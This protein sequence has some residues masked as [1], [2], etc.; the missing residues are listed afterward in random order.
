GNEEEV[1]KYFKQF[2]VDWTKYDHTEGSRERQNEINSIRKKE[3]FEEQLKTLKNNL[4]NIKG[5]ETS[6]PTRYEKNKNRIPGLEKKISEYE[7]ILRDY[8]AYYKKEVE[9]INKKYEDSAK[10]YIEKAKEDA[11]PALEALDKIGPLFTYADMS[12]NGESKNVA[13]IASD[14]LTKVG[15]DDKINLDKHFDLYSMYTHADDGNGYGYG[16]VNGNKVSFRNEIIAVVTLPE[17]IDIPDKDLDKN[18]SSKNTNYKVT[19]V[20]KA[21]RKLTIKLKSL[22]E[23]KYFKDYKKDDIPKLK[24]TDLNIKGL[25]FNDKTRLGEKYTI[26][27][28]VGG[29][30]LFAYGQEA[31]AYSAFAARQSSDGVDIASSSSNVISLTLKLKSNTV[32]FKVD[33]QPDK[34]VL[35]ETGKSINGDV[36]NTQSMPSD[37]TKSGYTFKGW[38]TQPNGGGTRF[39]GNTPVNSDITVY[40][41]FER[42]P[43]N[44]GGG[45]GGGTTPDPGRVDG[46]DRVETGIKI[47]QKY[48]DKAKTVIVVRHDLFP[49]SMTA[50]VLAKLK[51]APILLNPTNKLDPRVGAEIKRLGAEEVIIVGGPDSISEKVRGDLKA[52]DKDKDVERIAGVDRYGT[53]EMVARRVTGITGK[54]NTGV[55]ASGQVFP[56]ALSVGTFA[57]RDGYPI[58]LVKKNLVPDQVVRA[59][60]DLDIKKT[61]I[62]GGTNTISKSTEA[63]LPGVLERMAGKDR[64]E[65]SVAI[66]KSKFK[67]SR[68]AFIASGEEFADALVIS[69]VSGKYNR[70]T[71]LAS[72]N[73]K[74]NAVVKKYI[75][76][77]YLTSITAIGGEKYLPKSIMLD[78]AG[79]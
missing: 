5:W 74:T 7:E 30:G 17:N 11:K 64:Y 78:L 62:A 68:E 23:N 21:G 3:S 19:S 56:D 12:I 10:E 72:R 59:I 29:Y 66:A 18:I 60:K 6:D 4:N 16:T 54:K 32:T 39:D 13:E 34:P 31:P 77:S 38:F 28:T 58:L 15:L 76:E 35:V 37:P 71:L 14:D 65:T 63:K 45:G 67:D 40:A 50:S 25:T 36:D 55:I 61:Y 20:K 48:Y 53:S 47:S 51:D 22:I 9:R 33:G 42:T 24:N 43:S 46:D 52:Y 75:E 73:K 41:Y 69:P 2:L 57:S 8:D 49:D 1:G 27:E 26:T 44:P 79:K 70:P